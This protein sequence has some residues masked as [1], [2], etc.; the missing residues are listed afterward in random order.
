MY[1]KYDFGE[2]LATSTRAN[3]RI[4]DVIPEGAK[5]DFSREFLPDSLARTRAASRPPPR[6]TARGTWC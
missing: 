2:I 1:H 6:R 5:L 3:W 4:E